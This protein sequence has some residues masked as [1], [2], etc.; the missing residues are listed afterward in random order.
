[1]FPYTLK[2]GQ[3][4]FVRENGSLLSYAI[5]REQKDFDWS[6]VCIVGYPIK[7][8]PTLWTTGARWSWSKLAFLYGQVDAEKYLRGKQWCACDIIGITD[9]ETQLL[10]AQCSAMKDLPYNLSGVLE[11]VAVGNLQARE[12]R[13]LN[14]KPDMNPKAVFCSQSVYLAALKGPA[15]NLLDPKR[16]KLDPAVVSVEDLFYSPRI[17]EPVYRT[18]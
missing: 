11:L 15:I 12:V 5:R 1:M 7:G 3:V 14:A 13:S 8:R 17:S 9:K 16:R 6:H 10:I 2:P 18:D 4:I